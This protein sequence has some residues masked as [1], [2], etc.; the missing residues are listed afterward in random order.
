MYE[1]LF[2]ELAEKVFSIDS[3]NIEK[4]NIFIAIKGKHLDGH[5]FIKEAL[6][7]GAS[8]IISS[9][10]LNN[11]KVIYCDDTIKF[12]YEIAKFK[13][14]LIKA[15][16]ICITGSVGKTTVKENLFTILSKK[17]KTFRNYKNFN[18]DIGLPLSIL[19]T[20]LDAEYAIYEIGINKKDEMGKLSK[21]AKPDLSI[22]T[23]IGNAHLGNFKS[24]L[25][26]AEEKIKITLGM[27]EKSDLI[28]EKES[29]FT[30]FFESICKKSGINFHTYT[31][32]LY[33]SILDVLHI[34][35][36]I[37]DIEFSPLSGRGD[38]HILKNGSLLID[39]SYNSS[40]ESVRYCIKELSTFVNKR[41]ILVLGDILELGEKSKDIHE[42]I[43]PMLD[44]YQID[45]V[46]MCGDNLDDIFKKIQPDQQVFWCKQTHELI[47]KVLNFIECNDVIT[48]KA[49]HS[50]GLNKLVQKILKEFI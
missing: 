45:K 37:K 49:S 12:L 22:I 48:V 15:K 7:K 18:N 2:Y 23:M 46:F 42:Q 5:D 20:P 28:F 24:I 17:Y 44:K 27:P 4:G 6:S 34:K 29:A 3:R 50:I 10:K 13:R 19:N 32:S 21:L 25:E 47:D 26:I 1:K 38:K 40:L 41:K 11:N 8:Y 43:L 30:E 9:K 39:H 31:N 35:E 36:G 14:N 33:K 16:I